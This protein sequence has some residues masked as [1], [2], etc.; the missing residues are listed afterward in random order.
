MQLETYRAVLLERKAARLQKEMGETVVCATAEPKRGW[1]RNVG[2]ALARPGVMLATEPLVTFTCVYLALVNGIYYLSFES[3][4]MIYQG[5]LRA[6]IG[7]YI[8]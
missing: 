2:E 7:V 4:P 5:N 8:G 6:R 1:K 3:Y